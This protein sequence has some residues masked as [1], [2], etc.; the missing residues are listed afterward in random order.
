MRSLHGLDVGSGVH[1]VVIEADIILC[2]QHTDTAHTL[3]QNAS[4]AC[5]LPAPAPVSMV[6]H[7]WVCDVT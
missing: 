6:T 1:L 3:V 4:T 2:T 5:D 7:M